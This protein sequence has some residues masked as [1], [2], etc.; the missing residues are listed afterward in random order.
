MGSDSS[1]DDDEYDYDDDFEVGKVD[2]E[3]SIV[4]SHNAS[5]QESNMFY[6]I[7]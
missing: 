6:M 4:Y 2:F 7:F 5:R 1:L 3:T